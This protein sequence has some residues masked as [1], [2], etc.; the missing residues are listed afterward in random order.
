[1]I[2][3]EG[4]EEVFGFFTCVNY[5]AHQAK[6]CMQQ[7]RDFVLSKAGEDRDKVE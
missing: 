1:M 2:K 6:Q 5:Q 7:I 3:V 4:T